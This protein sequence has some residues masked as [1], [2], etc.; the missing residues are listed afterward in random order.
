MKNRKI[1]LQLSFYFVFWIFIAALSIDELKSGLINFSKNSSYSGSIS[2]VIGLTGIGVGVW[3]ILRHTYQWD[4]EKGRVKR[5]I[6][7]LR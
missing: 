4:L 5:H 3:R 2:I 7:L 1:R 6:K